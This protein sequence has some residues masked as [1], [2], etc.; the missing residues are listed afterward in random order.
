LIQ[1]LPWRDEVFLKE[2][3]C[4]EEDVPFNLGVFN[5]DGFTLP[6]N[7]FGSVLSNSV[8]LSSGPNS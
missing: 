7:S 4:T 3:P 8:S 2:P 1:E 6:I 5:D